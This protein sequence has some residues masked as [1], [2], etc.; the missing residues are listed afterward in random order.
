[1]IDE[2]MQYSNFTLRMIDRHDESIQLK[3][4]KTMKQIESIYLYYIC[5]NDE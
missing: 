5:K 2:D 3:S 1:M 4:I